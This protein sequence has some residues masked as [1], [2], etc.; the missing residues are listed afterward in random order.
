[1]IQCCK[2]KTQTGKREKNEKNSPEKKSKNNTAEQRARKKN[3]I[4][5]KKELFRD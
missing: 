2:K 1:M 4:E 3:E 5:G